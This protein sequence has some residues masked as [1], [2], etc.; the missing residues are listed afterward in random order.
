[1][2]A[3]LS[4]FGLIAVNIYEEEKEDCL[5]RQQEAEAL[6]SSDVMSKVLPCLCYTPHGV[7]LS[8]CKMFQCPLECRVVNCPR[9]AGGDLDNL[10]VNYLG[11]LK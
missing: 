4:Y 8:A 2:H 9:Q 3:H 5:K 1:M 6:S 10:M 7:L 11:D